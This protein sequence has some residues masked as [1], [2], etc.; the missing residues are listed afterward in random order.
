MMVIF[1]SLLQGAQLYDA[2]LCCEHFSES[3]AAQA[4]KHLS[5]ALVHLHALKIVHRDLKLEN[6]FV[7]ASLYLQVLNFVSDTL[8]FC[9]LLQLKL[10][11]EREWILKL[12]GMTLATTV[13]EPLSLVCGT[14]YY[15]APE[16]IT[17]TG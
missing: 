1:L 3:D 5:M 12:G 6:I 2:V 4:M 9:A 15:M 10:V 7:R 13:F 16:M 14:I 17:G 11:S 8:V